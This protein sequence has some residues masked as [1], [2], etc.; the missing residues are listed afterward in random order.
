MGVIIFILLV[1][2]GVSVYDYFDT[3]D[4]QSTTSNSRNSV[5]FEHRNKKYGAYHLRRDYNDSFGIIIGGVILFLALFFIVN[6]NI[7][8]TPVAITIPHMD[9]T[10]LTIAAPPVEEI[11]TIKTPYKIIGGGGGG[12]AGAA[13]VN[14]VDRNTREQN[15]KPTVISNSKDP[16]GQSD[17]TNSKNP[18]NN[19]ATT[20]V[21]GENPFGGGG[22]KSG[23]GSGIF[24]KDQGTGSGT[25]EGNGTNG[26][27]SGLGGGARKKLSGLDPDDIQSNENCR[28]VLIVYINAEGNV[29]RAEN[30][31]NNTTT[32]DISLINRL[33]ELVKRQVKYDKRPGTGLQKQTLPINV[34]AT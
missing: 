11:K 10:L 19:T 29:T 9:T 21:K 20:L 30:D 7:R 18:T 16:A 32:S 26:T 31:K 25:G 13:S 33:I 2:A 3:K 23:S 28:V 24:G 4:W 34:K 22:A 17:H 1:I 5:I 14:P 15:A 6:A 27:G 8:T 12:S